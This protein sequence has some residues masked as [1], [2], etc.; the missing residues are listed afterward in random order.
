MAAIDK[1]NDKAVE[2][3]YVT[4]VEGNY[5]FYQ[6]YIERSGV[7]EYADKE[8][9]VLKLKDGAIFVFG[10]MI[11]ILYY[12]FISKNCDFFIFFVCFTF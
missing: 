2:I 10:G 8:K 12:V 6:A 9:T 5:D 4:D 3:G 11:T 7:L 1:S